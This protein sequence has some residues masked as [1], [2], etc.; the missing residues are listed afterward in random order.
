MQK[1]RKVDRK[2]FAEQKTKDRVKRERLIHLIS[3]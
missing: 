3:T 1:E 2:A